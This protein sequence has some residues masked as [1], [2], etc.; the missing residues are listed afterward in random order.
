MNQKIKIDLEEYKVFFRDGLE[1]DHGKIID[2][3]QF[4]GKGF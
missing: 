3:L 2:F 1:R 4:D